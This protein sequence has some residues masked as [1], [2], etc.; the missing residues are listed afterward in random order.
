[1]ARPL[2]MLRGVLVLG[3]VTAS[4]MAAGEAHAQIYPDIPRLYAFLTHCDVFWVDIP[5][6]ILMGTLLFGHAIIIA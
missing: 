5:D 3:A 1:M 4:H 6:L 2:E